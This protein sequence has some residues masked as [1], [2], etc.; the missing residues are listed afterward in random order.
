MKIQ[1]YP[2]P[3]IDLREIDWE[4][5]KSEIKRQ[6]MDS[7]EDYGGLFLPNNEKYFVSNFEEIDN[8]NFIEIS[9]K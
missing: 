1:I 7:I 8:I 9:I 3:L 4:N 5:D 6:L 2:N